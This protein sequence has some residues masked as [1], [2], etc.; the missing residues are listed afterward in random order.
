MVWHDLYCDGSCK[1]H[2]VPP[3]LTRAAQLRAT[4]NCSAGK[5][6]ICTQP[7]VITQ[8]T[9]SSRVGAIVNLC[10]CLSSLLEKAFINGT[11]TKVFVSESTENQLF[12]V[13]DPEFCAAPYIGV[14]YCPIT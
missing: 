2:S 1:G 5:Y 13:Q 9:K 7:Y 11:D 10:R 14:F 3:G 12:S 6:W 4:D 8:I